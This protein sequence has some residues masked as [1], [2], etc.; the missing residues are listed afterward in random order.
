[1]AAGDVAFADKA[2]RMAMVDTDCRRQC[3]SG[4][5]EHGPP[6]QTSPK[7]GRGDH[8]LCGEV[9]ADGCGRCPHGRG[10]GRES[11]TAVGIVASAD[12]S[13]TA[14]GGVVSDEAARGEGKQGA[15]A[16]DET[17]D[18]QRGDV[19]SVDDTARASM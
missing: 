11:K 12:K 6:R 17:T 10:K 4:E 3:R 13:W 9:R 7:D 2:T 5:R 14:V 1:M 15:A 8:R 16:A 19:A 18:R